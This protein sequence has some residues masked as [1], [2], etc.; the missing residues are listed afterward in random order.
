MFGPTATTATNRSVPLAVL[1]GAFGS[2][3]TALNIAFPALTDA[4]ELDVSDLQWVVTCFVLS[5]GISLII[6]GRL[7]DRHGHGPV[8]AAGAVAAGIGLALCAA[9]PNLLTLL[10][11][12]IVQGLGTALVMA[13][14][15][16]L[17]AL[18]TGLDARGRAVGLFQTSA[19][20]GLA[21]GPIVGGPLVDVAGW[22]GVFWFRLPLAVVV[23][24]MARSLGALAEA[25]AS[26]QSA[27]TSRTTPWKQL[28]RSGDFVAAN[29]LAVVANGAMFATWLLVPS[30]LIDELSISILLAGLVLAA[31]PMA[32]A[33]VS[34]RVGGFSD[35]GYTGWLVAGGILLMAAGMAFIGGVAGTEPSGFVIAL[36]LAAVGLG[37]GAFSVPNMATVMG[38]LPADQQGLGS[39]LSLTTRTIGIVVGVNASSRIFD[40]LRLDRPY[41]QSFSIVFYVMAIVLALAG[42][43]EI[44]RRVASRPE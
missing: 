11:G 1:A 9:A 30:L 19:G 10:A 38:A 36:G 25:P 5:Y 22:R 29:V 15:P 14:A 3:D 44:M 28:L 35:R 43:L 16:A 8:M 34:P 23:L 6:A 17:I 40:R 12:R 4:F 21:I 41:F 26:K 37:L 13:S 18:A 2:L 20:I 42:S 31:S 39:G 33:L 32:T 7:G 27:V 24:L